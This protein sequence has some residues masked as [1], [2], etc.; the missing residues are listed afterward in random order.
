MGRC[1]APLQAK[2]TK[3]SLTSFLF[4]TAI[5]ISLFKPCFVNF[6]NKTFASER[7]SNGDQAELGGDTVDILPAIEGNEALPQQQQHQIFKMIKINLGQVDKIV[8]AYENEVADLK[9]RRET[10]EDLLYEYFFYFIKIN[11]HFV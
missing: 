7:F 4:I 1:L 2:I 5:N 8:E 10:M 9:R 6:E 3:V 11:H